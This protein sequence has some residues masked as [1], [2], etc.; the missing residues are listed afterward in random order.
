MIAFIIAQFLKDKKKELG[1]NQ[2]N[3][4]YSL[5]NICNGD[6]SAASKTQNGYKY[7]RK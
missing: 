5:A 1:L 6:T 4:T 7:L 3:Y 2:N